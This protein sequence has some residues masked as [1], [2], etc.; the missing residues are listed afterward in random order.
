[1]HSTRF[2]RLC[3]LSQLPID[4][5]ALRR[6]PSCRDPFPY[7]IVPRSCVSRLCGHTS[8]RIFCGGGGMDPTFQHNVAELG[9]L[10]CRNS[11]AKAPHS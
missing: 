3:P 10:N 2:Q 7:S 1:M 8:L 5:D 9:A 11:S 6:A 4:I